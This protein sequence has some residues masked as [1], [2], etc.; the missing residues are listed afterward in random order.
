MVFITTIIKFTMDYKDRSKCTE[1]GKRL[2][3]VKLRAVPLEL[4]YNIISYLENDRVITEKNNTIEQ[5]HYD[6]NNLENSFRMLEDY[7]ERS[8][9]DNE[10]LLQRNARL[11]ARIEQLE[12][13]Y[14]ELYEYHRNSIRQTRRRINFEIIDLNSDTSDNEESIIV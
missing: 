1:C 14:N 4:R 13:Q 7:S 3:F 8:D 5:L 10:R 2:F 6:L 12:L 11:T 9:R